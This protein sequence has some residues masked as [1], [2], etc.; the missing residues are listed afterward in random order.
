MNEKKKL[1]IL[2]QL[3]NYFNMDITKLSKNALTIL[4]NKNMAQAAIARGAGN[5]VR[6][7]EHDRLANLIS[8]ER[9]KRYD[10]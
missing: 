5:E 4:I 1:K 3:L 9:K 7:K 6:A 2:I 10:K 8:A